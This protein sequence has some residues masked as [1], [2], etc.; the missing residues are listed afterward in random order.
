MKLVLRLLLVV[1]VALGVFAGAGLVATWAPDRTVAQL[2]A[3]WAQSPSQFV[4]VLGMQVHIRDEGPRDDP[5][6]VVL[7]HGT[8]DSL[9]TWEGWSQNLKGQRRVIRFDLPAFGLTGPDAENDYSIAAYVRFVTAVLDN[10]GVRSFV[11]AGNSLG[12]QIAW[13]TALALPQRVHQLVL[14]DAAGY[15]LQPQ[16]VPIGFQIARMPGARGLMEYVLPR[17]VVESSVRNVYGDPSRVTPGLVDRYYELAL[18][19]GNRKALASRLGQRVSGDEARIKN[20]KVPTLILW[21]GADH[22][23]PLDNAKRFAADIAGSKLVVF[24]GLGHVPQEEDAQATVRAL[25]SFIG[26]R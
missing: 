1:V 4:N 6:P 22:L 18:R 9:H 23:I 14:V 15:P 20:V 10:L 17:G 26:L 2:S 19:A 3:R 13:N 25:R 7:L 21:G 16:S 8:S 24:D 11:L 12:G 5:Y